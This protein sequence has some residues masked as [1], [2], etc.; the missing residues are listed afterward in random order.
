MIMRDTVV[1][2]GPGRHQGE[3]EADSR[4]M[5]QRCGHNAGGKSKRLRPWGCGHSTGTYGRGGSGILR[6]QP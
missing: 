4:I 5:R 6:W 3:Y 1:K 2:V